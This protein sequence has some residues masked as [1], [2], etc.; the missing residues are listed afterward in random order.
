MIGLDS[1]GNNVT[2]AAAIGANSFANK[3]N[4]LVL[5][6]INGLN[7]ATADGLV[8]IGTP[9]PA[10]RLHVVQN[11]DYQ[12]RLQSQSAGGGYWNIGQTDNLFNS[13]GGKLAFVPDSTDSNTAAVVFSNSGNVG[14]GTTAPTQRLHINSATGNAAALVQTPSSSFA[15]YQLK[16]GSSNA[17]TLGTQSD[18]SNGALLLRNGAT[19]EVKIQ[20]DGT[21]SQLPAAN[22]LV[23]AMLLVNA[24]GSINL[25]YNSQAAPGTCGVTANYT[26]VGTY[27]ITFPFQVNVRFFSLTV[28]DFN[29]ATSTGVLTL[30]QTQVRVGM[31]DGGPHRFYLMVF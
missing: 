26:G 23:K 4:A 24:D 22:G 18:F 2:N 7:G 1:L 13:G 21:I 11:G 6:S 20:T 16:S 25:C 5:G 12:L 27:D 29:G 10:M 14:V 31:N 17:W 28:G 15:Q 30:N 8:G 19:D 3:S 9:S